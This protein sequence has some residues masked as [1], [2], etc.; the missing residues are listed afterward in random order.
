MRKCLCEHKVEIATSHLRSSLG[1]AHTGFQCHS[2]VSEYMVQC[3]VL[4]SQKSDNL[5]YMMQHALYAFR[6]E[7]PQGST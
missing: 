5:L 7:L 1:T 4:E 2:V 3:Q 6:R